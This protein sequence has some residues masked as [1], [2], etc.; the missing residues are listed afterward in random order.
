MGK[1]RTLTLFK[2]G[3]EVSCRRTGVSMAFSSKERPRPSGPSWG[4][5]FRTP[6]AVTRYGCFFFP[7]KEIYL[8]AY[9]SP[10]LPQALVS[11]TAQSGWEAAAR[12]QGACSHAKLPAG[13]ERG[14]PWSCPLLTAQGSQRLKLGLPGMV[15]GGLRPL[16]KRHVRGLPLPHPADCEMGTASKSPLKGRT[17][18]KETS[19]RGTVA[20]DGR[21]SPPGQ[22]GRELADRKGR[23]RFRETF[24]AQVPAC[25][26]IGWWRAV[27][28]G[29]FRRMSTVAVLIGQGRCQSTGQKTSSGTSRMNDLAQG[30]VM[31]E[32]HARP[33]R[34]VGP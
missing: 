19:A 31:A 20:R 16:G 23:L 18:N 13:G 32:D 7:I 28:I 4:P 21:R 17:E 1:P 29:L 34:E 9:L 6:F 26:L 5:L 2:A 11:T 27:L 15:P 33:L 14:H 12:F 22:T 8:Q 30:S 25:I 10:A 3:V 24:P